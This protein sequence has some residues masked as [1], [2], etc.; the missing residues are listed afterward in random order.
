MSVLDV[1]VM[2]LFTASC[3]PT[4]VKCEVSTAPFAPSVSQTAKLPTTNVEPFIADTK[5]VIQKPTDQL[6]T[7]DHEPLNIPLHPDS[8]SD[9]A[10]VVS[11]NEE[12]LDTS[13]F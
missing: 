9:A 2:C 3:S 6:S 4:T 1:V 7:A 8:T 10:P 12:S 13:M 5:S 11:L